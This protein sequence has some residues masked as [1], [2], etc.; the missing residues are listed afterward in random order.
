[1]LW[2]NATSPGSQPRND[3]GPLVGGSTSA[4]VRSEVSYG[5]PMFALSWRR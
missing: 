5:A 3:G 2:P 1:M 4:V